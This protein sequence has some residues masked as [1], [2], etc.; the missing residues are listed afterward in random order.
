M[1]LGTRLGRL[2]IRAGLL[3]SG[4]SCCQPVNCTV[5]VRV[6]APAYFVSIGFTSPSSLSVTR[7]CGLSTDITF[8]NFGTQRLSSVVLFRENTEWR[9]RVGV[10]YLG[11]SPCGLVQRTYTFGALAVGG[12]GLPSAQSLPFV[13]FT[14]TEESRANCPC[15]EEYPNAAFNVCDN[16]FP[17]LLE[18]FR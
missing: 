2:L 6:K 4:C 13:G 12:D 9:C 16:N 11:A 7:D 3:Q 5:G 1:S 10:F 18:I 15:F 8:T 14:M 17:S